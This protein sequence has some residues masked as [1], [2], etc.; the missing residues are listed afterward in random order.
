MKRTNCPLPFI[1]LKSANSFP[2]LTNF[3]EMKEW[4]QLPRNPRDVRL[5]A[6][7]IVLDIISPTSESTIILRSFRFFLQHITS[8]FV[9]GEGEPAA[10]HRVLSTFQL[11]SPSRF[12]DE[13]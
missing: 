8:W 5:L 1:L 2:K 4:Y 3:P 12:L 7:L 10:I 6:R 13:N 9:F 11:L